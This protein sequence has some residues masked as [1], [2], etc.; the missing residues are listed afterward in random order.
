[1]RLLIHDT[2][3]TAPFVLAN[4]LVPGSS[5]SELVSTST[6]TAAEV[7][8]GDAALLPSAEAS[9]LQATHAI[10]PAAAVVF[11][12]QGPISMRTPVRP[13]GVEATTVRL[14]D[15]S[16]TAE[17]L[18][19]ATLHDFY[20]ITASAWSAEPDAE[21]QVAIVEGAA[22]LSAPEAGFAEDLVRAWFIMTGQ[23]VVTHLFVVPREGNVSAAIERMTALRDAAIEHRRDLRKMIAEKYE[24]DR[25]KLIDLAAVTRYELS[26]TDRRALLMLLQHGNKGFRYPYVWNLDFHGEEPATA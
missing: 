13:D 8:P 23:P 15:V 1:V 12:G 14:F 11:E 21:A 22:A 5:E 7:G 18:A 9:E 10:V 2:L 17:V 24:I 19:R 20:G 26:E 25:E 6:L 3:A 16:S 4:E